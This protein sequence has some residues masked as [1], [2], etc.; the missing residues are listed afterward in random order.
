MGVLGGRDVRRSIDN[1]LLRWQGRLDG[2][3]ADRWLPWAIA[4]AQ[5]I[6]LSALALARV[7]SLEAGADLATYAQAA[8]LI[9]RGEVPHLTIPGADLLE[10]QS[11]LDR[12]SV[13]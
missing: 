10:I 13:V 7:R 2:D 8:W 11:S 6:C 9:G 4:A 5:A 3:A 12:K 1:A